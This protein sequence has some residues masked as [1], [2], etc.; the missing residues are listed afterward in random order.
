MITLSDVT[1]THFNERDVEV[2]A[3]LKF[4]NEMLAAKSDCSLLDV[5]GHYAHATYGP[6]IRELLKNNIYDACD[7]LPDPPTEK[8]V[9]NYFVGNVSEL[10]LNQ[11]DLV[12]CISVIEHCGLTTYKRDDIYSEQCLIMKRLTDLAQKGL[13]LTFPYGLP[14]VYP[15]Q[16]SNIFDTLLSKFTNQWLYSKGPAAKVET[17]FFYNDF[18]PKGLP[19]SELTHEQASQVPLDV[20]LGIVQCVCLFKA[21]C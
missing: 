13:F 16:Y 20:D 14:G 18:S 10:S 19:W 8:L 3:V 11:Y 7:I 9:N 21:T 12:T 5:G 15:D 4:T 1:K 2:P 17:Q 6:G